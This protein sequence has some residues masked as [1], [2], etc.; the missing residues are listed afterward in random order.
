M[1]LLFFRDVTK[2]RVP[3]GQYVVAEW[4]S[5]NKVTKIPST[6]IEDVDMNCL[7][8]IIKND[9][10]FHSFCFS[11]GEKSEKVVEYVHGDGF[12]A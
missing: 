9:S 8:L 2:T 4:L 7:L 11:G 3:N 5:F 1:L 12:G 10:F 6:H